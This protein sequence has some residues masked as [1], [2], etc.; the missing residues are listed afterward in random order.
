MRLFA[1]AA[2]ATLA[3]AGLSVSPAA[4]RP[5]HHGHGWNHGRPGHGW[6]GGHHRRCTTV[7]R[8]HHRVRRCW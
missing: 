3:I 2:A 1:I 5:G 8:H 4:A 6:H 7:W